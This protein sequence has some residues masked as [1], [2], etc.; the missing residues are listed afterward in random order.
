MAAPQIVT[1]TLALLARGQTGN[2]RQASTRAT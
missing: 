2:V 1:H